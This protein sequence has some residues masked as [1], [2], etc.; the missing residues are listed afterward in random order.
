MEVWKP[1]TPDNSFLPFPGSL[2]WA[3]M[4]AN[5]ILPPGTLDLEGELRNYSHGSTNQSV[6]R[7][8]GSV[9]QTQLF[10][11][12]ILVM[13]ALQPPQQFSEQSNSFPKNSLNNSLTVSYNL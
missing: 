13:M 7:K 1:K 4:W 5:L 8:Q 3:W 9:V 6:S 10:Y 12:V 2:M 11:G